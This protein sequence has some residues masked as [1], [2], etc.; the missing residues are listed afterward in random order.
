M[1]LRNNAKDMGEIGV[2]GRKSG[3]ITLLDVL[4]A[5]LA[6][7]VLIYVYFINTDNTLKMFV[8]LLMAI[9]LS[10]LG[11]VY[12]RMPVERP[13]R[14]AIAKLV[15]LNEDGESVKEWYIQGETSL[16]I[17]K[18]SGQN[19]VDIDLA[20]AEYA[21]LIQSEHAVLNRSGRE[22]FIEDVDSESGVGI[23]KSGRGPRDKQE[24]EEPHKLDVGDI[25]YIANTR[26]LVK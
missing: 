3:W 11:F 12:Y 19:E 1:V 10:V 6:A 17:G 15:L 16:L 18:S 2:K 26:L 13:E 5:G 20:D 9:G 22:W 8:S 23:Q 14:E 4:I 25:V 24:V 7:A 21:S